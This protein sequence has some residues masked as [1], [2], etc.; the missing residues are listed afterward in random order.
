MPHS[1]VLFELENLLNYRGTVEKDFQHFFEQHP[2]LLTGLDFRKAHP[3][4]LLYKDDGTS[5]IPDFFLE[6]LDNHWDTILDLKRPY[7]DMV[8]R[9][10]N[11]VYF[12]QAIHNAAAQLRYY[13]EWFE[14][15]TNRKTFE[16]CMGYGRFGP[17][18]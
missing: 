18:W 13:S 3:Q 15:P 2:F 8:V 9:R 16:S 5:L 12:S 7:E 11:R 17:K 14:S 6:K 10:K 4:P 1:F